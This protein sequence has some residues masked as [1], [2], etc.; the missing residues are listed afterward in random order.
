MR[1]SKERLVD[2]WGISHAGGRIERNEPRGVGSKV[3][4]CQSEFD[5]DCVG[6]RIS[7]CG[8]SRLLHSTACAN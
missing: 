3:V 8:D 7:R 4:Q 6:I 5:S 2:Y 1:V